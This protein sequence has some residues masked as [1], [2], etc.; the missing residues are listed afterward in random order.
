MQ[1]S[2]EDGCYWSKYEPTLRLAS[3]G[4]VVPFAAEMPTAG[5]RISLLRTSMRPF[6]IQYSN[7]DLAFAIRRRSVSIEKKLAAERRASDEGVM[8]LGRDIVFQSF[9]V[10]IQILLQRNGLR[11][12]PGN[13]FPGLA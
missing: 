6:C 11:Q 13:R 1:P 4:T 10:I 7:A 2:T 8:L 5:G 9:L 12:H 3:I